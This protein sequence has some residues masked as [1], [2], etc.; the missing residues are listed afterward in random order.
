[1]KESFIGIVKAIIYITMLNFTF[2]IFNFLLP[3]GSDIA[4]FLAIGAIVI[5]FVD[6]E[7]DKQGNKSNN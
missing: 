6:R 4:T 5:H 1:M 7:L 3:R 2:W